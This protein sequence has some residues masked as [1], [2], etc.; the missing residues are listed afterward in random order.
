MLTLNEISKSIKD[1]TIV[2][3]VSFEIKPGS[4]N[5]LLGPNGAGKTTTFY[6]IAGLIKLDSGEIFFNGN[7]ISN[8]PMHKRSNMGIKYLPQEPS[9]FQDLTVYENLYGLAEISLKEK[10]KISQ[11]M[12]QSIEEFSLEQILDL[13][14]RQLS[15]GQRRKVEIARTLAA[16][17]KIILLDEPFAGID[18]IAIDEIKNVL[19]TLKD[20]G[21]AIL[22][23]DHNVREALDICDN[24]IVVNRGRVIAKG[25][26]ADLINNDLVKKVY[27]GNMYS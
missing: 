7:D 15:G 13:K 12:T 6:L 4:V 21:I 2:D 11:F 17:P 18:P 9:I 24:A 1:K 5:G 14:G 16:S 8:L 19:R 22:I 26:K 3:K 27:L 10:N 23:T 25:V 20:K